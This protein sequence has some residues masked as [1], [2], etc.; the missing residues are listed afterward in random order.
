MKRHCSSLDAH[1]VTEFRKQCFPFSYLTNENYNFISNSGPRFLF[2]GLKI[3]AS[4]SMF[5]FLELL[6][7][8]SDFYTYSY[9]NI[10]WRGHLGDYM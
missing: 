3:S 7:V 8:H 4:L 9:G 2:T 5:F 1:H 10:T 6:P